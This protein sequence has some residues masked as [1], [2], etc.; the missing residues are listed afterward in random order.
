MAV[1]DIREVLGRPGPGTPREGAALGP[2]VLDAIAGPEVLR[3]IRDAVLD[4]CDEVTL[5]G[6]EDEDLRGELINEG[7]LLAFADAAVRFCGERHDVAEGVVPPAD[8]ARYADTYQALGHV[9][10]AAGG[11]QLGAHTAVLLL[12]AELT[13]RNDEVQERIDGRRV[14]ADVT[15]RRVIDALFGSAGAIRQEVAGSAADRRARVRLID[16]KGAEQVAG[17]LREASLVQ[18]AVRGAALRDVPLPPL[19]ISTGDAARPAGRSKKK[20]KP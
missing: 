19:Q 9:E 6:A 8:F 10:R 7:D 16:E 20:G 15:A 2:A 3:E 4:A 12:S 5:E 14:T 13:R 17:A 1:D 11:L 18:A